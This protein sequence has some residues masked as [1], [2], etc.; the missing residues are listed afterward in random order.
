MNQQPNAKKFQN[1]TSLSKKK[2]IMKTPQNSSRPKKPKGILNEEISPTD[3]NHDIQILQN[4]I[5][6]T[7]SLKEAKLRINFDNEE[8]KNF[9]KVKK[10]KKKSEGKNEKE[11]K[12]S[13]GDKNE[14]VKKEKKTDNEKKDSSL[15][16]DSKK[17]SPRKSPK[18]KFKSDLSPQKSSDKLQ[19]MQP[20]KALASL[21]MKAESQLS[22]AP[23]REVPAE[24]TV[25]EGEMFWGRVSGH[26][27][28]PCM[29]HANQE[30][31]FY[32]FMKGQLTTFLHLIQK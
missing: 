1:T 6:Q 8:D 17:D 24:V 30:G 2:S 27:W 23:P 25:G 31:L 10:P 29:V 11:K 12:I 16:V 18:K 5:N 19:S 32:K 22:P 26:P 20:Y 9:K 21:E 7:K 4:E 3:I 15:V 13:K 14:I 28:W